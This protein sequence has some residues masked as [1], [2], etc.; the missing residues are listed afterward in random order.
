M[1]ELERNV[2]YLNKALFVVSW[3]YGPGQKNSAVS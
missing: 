3:Y 1:N 2:R